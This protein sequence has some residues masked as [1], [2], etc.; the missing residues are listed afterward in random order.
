MVATH[1]VHWEKMMLQL[2][3]F[4]FG[5]T[6]A[7]HVSREQPAGK[8]RTLILILIFTTAIPI[9]LFGAGLAMAFAQIDRDVITPNEIVASAFIHAFLAM[10]VTPFCVFSS[11]GVSDKYSLYGNLGHWNRFAAF[12]STFPVGVV[13]SA[14]I[15]GFRLL[16]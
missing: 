7:W 4:F 10:I 8:I 12:F 15:R 11:V 2:I 14:T 1:S 9:L 3:V 16:L 5:M 13:L 6:F